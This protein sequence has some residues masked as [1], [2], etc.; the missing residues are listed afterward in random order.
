MVR[1][2]AVNAG[3]QDRYHAI[4]G[5]LLYR[6][7]WSRPDIA[8][9]VSELSRFVSCPG[10]THM[11]AAKH[12]LRHLNGAKNLG[13]VYSVPASRANIL[14]GYLDSD[15]AGCPDSRTSTS[16]YA[17]LLNGAAAI[18]WHCSFVSGS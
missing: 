1:L 5:S 18:S 15:W 2:S 16:G 8:F 3:D 10:Q 4:V 14:W 6:A 12:L 13:L 9:A 11:I 17:P 7:C